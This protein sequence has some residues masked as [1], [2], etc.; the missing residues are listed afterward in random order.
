MAIPKDLKLGQSPFIH[1]A[2]ATQTGRSRDNKMSGKKTVFKIITGSIFP[3]VTTTQIIA[4]HL[5]WHPNAFIF[6]VFSLS[7]IW[8]L[9]NQWNLG[10][11]RSVWM[12]SSSTSLIWEANKL[13]VEPHT[14]N[15]CLPIESSPNW[16][17]CDIL[18]DALQPPRCMFLRI[19]KGGQNY[20]QN[21]SPQQVFAKKK[22][23]SHSIVVLLHEWIQCEIQPW[24]IWV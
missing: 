7:R 18:I 12:I 5:A 16:N 14:W 3:A 13:V 1:H 20:L 9:R 11:L 17:T 22:L 23:D 2:V 8:I 15:G 21:K 24:W 4:N 10:P 6:R 19:A